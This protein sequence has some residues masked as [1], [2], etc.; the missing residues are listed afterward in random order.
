MARYTD[1]LAA[2]VA[3][4]QEL[5]RRIGERLALERGESTRDGLSEEQVALA[6][7]AILAWQQQGEEEQ[8]LH[9]FRAMGPLQE[10]LVEH[11]AALDRIDDIH[12]RRLS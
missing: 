11:R 12:D 7:A 6:E 10:L 2:I 3:Y 1:E 5:R 9:A 4:E 8:D